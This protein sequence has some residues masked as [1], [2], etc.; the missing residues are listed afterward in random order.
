MI[1]SRRC[2]YALRAVLHLARQPEGTPVP[3]RAVSRTL[4]V[5]HAFLSKAVGDLAAAGIVETQPGTGGGVMLG[6]PAHAISL[7]DVV[8]VLDGPAIF[9]GCVL[10]LPGCGD[11]V[12][13]PLH[14]A[15]VQA[16]ERIDHLFSTTSLADVAGEVDSD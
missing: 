3:V 15:W 12:P 11:H 8:L 1:L 10:R 2:E 4:E 13:C 6:R 14:D 16:R 9:E 5:P 7:K